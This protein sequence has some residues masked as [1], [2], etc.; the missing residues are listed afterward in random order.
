MKIVVTTSIEVR[1]NTGEKVGVSEVVRTAHAGDN[2]AFLGPQAELLGNMAL[3]DAVAGVV[4]Q[5]GQ[6]V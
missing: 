5:T 6:K 2:P 4:A 1:N 3:S